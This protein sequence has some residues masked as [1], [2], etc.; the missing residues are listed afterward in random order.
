[1]AATTPSSTGQTTTP[2][3]DAPLI[4]LSIPMFVSAGPVSGTAVALA[5]GGDELWYLV[6]HAAAD[7]A[8]VWVHE[9]AITKCFVAP[10]PVDPR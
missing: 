8:P 3:A 1:M 5:R 7:G 10:M 2:P 9:G 6:D 4:P